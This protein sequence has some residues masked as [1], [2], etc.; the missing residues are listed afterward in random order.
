ML[1]PGQRACDDTVDVLVLRLPLEVGPDLSETATIAAGSP[2]RR[3]D[4]RTSKS[5]PDARLT[6]SITSDTEKPSE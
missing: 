3:G 4:S 2:A 6:A 1:L 5:T